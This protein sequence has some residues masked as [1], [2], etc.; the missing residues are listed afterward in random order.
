[1]HLKQSF[2]KESPELSQEIHTFMHQSVL[3]LKA[4]G[5]KMFFVNQRND[6][7]GNTQVTVTGLDAVDKPM[8]ASML[9]NGF[10]II[11]THQFGVEA[12]HVDGFEATSPAVISANLNAHAKKEELVL[13]GD[14]EPTPETLKPHN[15]L[16]P[17]PFKDVPATQA[18]IAEVFDSTFSENDA[19]FL[20]QC[21]LKADDLTENSEAMGRY[22][23]VLAQIEPHYADEPSAFVRDS[24]ISPQGRWLYYAH[25]L[26]PLRQVA[27]DPQTLHM[28]LKK[29]VNVNATASDARLI[30][31][32]LSEKPRPPKA[33]IAN[34]IQAIEDAFKK[35]LPHFSEGDSPQALTSALT[36]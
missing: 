6:D 30:F 10:A 8:L 28:L 19:Q 7:N 36:P 11:D 33:A 27:N 20:Y 34:I 32:L 18:F 14:D 2:K 16:L 29:E 15:A 23:K 22:Q 9:D 12:M 1:M 31:S 4:K 3:E 25:E 17:F 5:M 35:Y 21:G 26:S 24:L 13:P